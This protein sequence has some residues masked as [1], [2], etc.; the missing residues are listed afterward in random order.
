MIFRIDSDVADKEKG[1]FGRQLQR[2]RQ[3]VGLTQQDFADLMETGKSYISQLENGAMNPSL[4]IMVKYAHFFGVRFFQLAD[5]R[6]P[7]PPFE[8][9]PAAS[10]KLITQIKKQQQTVKSKQEQQKALS[11]EEG[12]PGRAKRLHALVEAGFFKKP[13]TAKEVFSRLFP[14]VKKEDFPSHATEQ[15][16]ILTT[17]SKGR[18]L[19]LLDKL[20]PAPGT[21]AV[22]FVVKDASV[23]KYLDGATG[24][25]DMA[26]DGE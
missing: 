6:F 23:V 12:L 3:A 17:L 20:E 5:A 10:R 11:K 24:T 13:K 2:Y 8:K 4:E 9:L 16:L 26:A 15:N 1:E 19:K 14:K 22:R 21:T 18:F 7:E 25:K